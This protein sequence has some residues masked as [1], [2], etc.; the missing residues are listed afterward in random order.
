MK[1][2]RGGVERKGITCKNP[3]KIPSYLLS[4]SAAGKDEEARRKMS[5][6]RRP[7]WKRKG[8]L[9]KLCCEVEEGRTT[10]ES[11]E[12]SNLLTH[13]KIWP[14]PPCNPPEKEKKLKIT[15]T[16]TDRPRA[17]WFYGEGR[18]INRNEQAF[19]WKERPICEV[20]KKKMVKVGGGSARLS[21]KKEEGVR[22]LIRKR[23]EGVFVWG[24]I[25][26]F[27]ILYSPSLP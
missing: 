19:W 17:S 14:P 21:V 8:E 23:R 5:P 20:R 26:W 2:W 16:R 12:K 13:R 24:E 6:S 4:P 25:R 18:A 1:E 15:Y 7:N 3:K 11:Q 22:I 27:M 9:R 10:W